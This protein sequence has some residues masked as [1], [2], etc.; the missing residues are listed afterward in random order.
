MHNPVFLKES[1]DGLNIKK[2]GLY[3]DATLGEGGHSFEI[4][5]RG[6]KVLAIDWDDK[7]ISNSKYQIA[8]SGSSKKIKLVI[9][10]FANIEKIAKENNFFPVDGVLFDLGLS[11]NQ[12]K[13]S[14]RG[15]SYKK[16]DEPLDMRINKNLKISAAD[17]VNSLNQNQLYEILAR[18]GEEINSL[19]I[20][21]TLVRARSLREIKTVG[22]LI[23]IIEKATGKKNRLIFARVFQALRIA[24]NDELEN[25]KKG[26]AGA[27]RV[28]KKR[29]RLVVISFH[30]LEDRIVKQFVKMNNLKQ[31]N[32]K[33]ITS[34]RLSEFERSAKMRIISYEPFN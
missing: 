31:V 9:G 25:L 12:I 11:M 1:I 18:Y 13:K 17:L 4:V 19:A 23:R 26:L 2:D 3:I 10:N 14:G 29:G 34:K 22:D 27:L 32:K 24:V 28:S 33:V 16:L 7:Q 6:G 21:R 5:K 30:S 8:K 15:F 20:V